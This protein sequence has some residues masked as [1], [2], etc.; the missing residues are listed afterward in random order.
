MA[1]GMFI[2]GI[3]MIFLKKRYPM[4]GMLSLVLGSGY[5]LLGFLN[6]IGLAHLN[7]PEWPFSVPYGVTLSLMGFVIGFMIDR[8][9]RKL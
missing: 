4:A 6:G 3:A 8:H 1:E 7:W 5:A 9:K 2:P